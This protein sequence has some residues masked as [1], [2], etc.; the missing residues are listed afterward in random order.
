[1]DVSRKCVGTPVRQASH[2]AILPNVALGEIEA[3]PNNIVGILVG[4]IIQLYIILPLLM[5][6]LL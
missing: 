4:T 3:G 5:V 1:M 6:L 2:V